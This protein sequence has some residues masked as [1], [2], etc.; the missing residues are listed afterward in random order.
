VGKNWFDNFLPVHTRETARQSFVTLM[1]GEM[2]RL[3]RYETEITTASGEPRIISWY[4]SLLER[5]SGEIHGTLGAGIDITKQKQAEEELRRSHEEM[6]QRVIERTLEVSEKTAQLQAIYNAIPDLVFILNHKGEVVSFQNGSEKLLYKSPG[7]FYGKTMHDILPPDVGRQFESA[8]E[9]VQNNKS[10]ATFEYP[11]EINNQ[12]KWF[13]ARLLPFTGE[14]NVAIIEDVSDRKQM[15]KQLRL[16]QKKLNDVSQVSRLGEMATG[17]AHELNQP[18]GAIL[19]YANSGQEL[20]ANAD[21]ATQMQFGAIFEK[22]V[23]LSSHAGGIVRQLRRLIEKKAP[24]FSKVD[25]AEP[26]L[27]LLNLMDSDLRKNNVSVKQQMGHANRSTIVDEIQIQQ[28]LMNLIRN[29]VDSMQETDRDQRTLNIA[30]LIR[31]DKLIE[32]AICDN[33]CGVHNKS[34]EQ[35]FDHFFTTKTEGLGV[36]LSISRDIIE[37]HKGQLWMT[38]NSGRGLTFHFTLPTIEIGLEDNSCDEL[39]VEAT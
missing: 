11:L 20:L 37:R 36:G 13:Q 24:V 2:R 23:N 33:G 32:V 34:K 18:L 22:L 7:E 25:I 30:T 17:L 10:S 19:L 35:I 8:L 28:V 9:E 21:T 31:N 12:E 1:Q 6:E 14:D 16:Q 39:T 3:E 27:S 26:I 29:A 38:P 15:E 5:D 4:Y